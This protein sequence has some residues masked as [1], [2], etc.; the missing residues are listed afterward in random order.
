MSQPLLRVDYHQGYDLLKTD[1]ALDFDGGTLIVW[2][3]KSRTHMLKAYGP[4]CGWTCE[5]ATE[6]GSD[7][8][9]RTE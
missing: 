6:G 8:E 7:G 4:G 9:V 1:G 3:D 2:R 5:W